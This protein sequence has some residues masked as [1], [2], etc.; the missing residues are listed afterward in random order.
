MEQ[1]T[2]TSSIRFSRIARYIL[3]RDDDAKCHPQ[4]NINLCEKPGISDK[5]TGIAI[6]VIAGAIVIGVLSVLI[7]LHLR[8]K[9]RDE[10]EWSGKNLQELEDYGMDTPA[11]NTVTRPGKTYQQQPTTIPDM[12]PR[13][14]QNNSHA[15]D[16]ARD[17]AKRNSL[18]ALARDLRA[19][20]Q[21]RNDDGQDRDRKKY[22]ARVEDEVSYDNMKPVE[23]VS[24]V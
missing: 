2:P 20:N 23:P 22:Q 11:S 4:P 9:K 13:H 21:N 1:T 18:D 16:G 8:R 19:H 5:T 12:A 17:S 7:F 24:Q 15:G 10:Q 3:S 14:H 6:G